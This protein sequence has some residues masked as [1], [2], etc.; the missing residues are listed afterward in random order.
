MSS[1]VLPS[2]SPCN[3]WFTNKGTTKKIGAREEEKKRGGGED[4]ER[5][6]VL[7]WQSQLYKLSAAYKTGTDHQSSGQS[8]LDKTLAKVVSSDQTWQQG[9]GRSQASVTTFKHPKKTI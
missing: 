2:S 8:A 4:N 5:W 1:T 7:E 3:A 6:Q 9:D